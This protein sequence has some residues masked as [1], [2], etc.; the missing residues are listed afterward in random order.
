[1]FELEGVH[2]SVKNTIVGRVKI[3]GYPEITEAEQK[4][5]GR[6]LGPRAAAEASVNSKP[7]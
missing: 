4:R 1:V 2:G 5:D 3:M 6:K 7:L